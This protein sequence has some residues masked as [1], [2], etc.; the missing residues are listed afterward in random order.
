MAY[1]IAGVAGL[2]GALFLW[3]AWKAVGRHSEWARGVILEGEV[4]ELMERPVPGRR[5]IAHPA[6]TPVVSYK[7]PTGEPGRF[8]STLGQYPSPYALGDKVAVRYLAGGHP[9]AEL[10]AALTHPS[11]RGSLLMGLLFSVIALLITFWDQ[12]L[13]LFPQHP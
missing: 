6:V 8:A 12:L 11:Q 7:T 2:V 5:V 9:P 10:D 1:V 4:V 3:D 13:A